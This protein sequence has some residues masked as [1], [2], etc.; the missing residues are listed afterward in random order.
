MNIENYI[1]TILFNIFFL[2]IILNHI[3]RKL[4]TYV[5]NFSDEQYEEY[6][7]S[8]SSNNDVL[9]NNKSLLKTLKSKL[10]NI[11][12]SI[13]KNIKQIKENTK[14]NK[15]S[16]KALDGD[17]DVDNSKACEKFPEAC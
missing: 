8:I 13:N 14:A 15:D 17:D 9:N 10:K 1:L 16:E 11:S 3:L 6:E 7:L 5:E 2:S 4:F 12:K